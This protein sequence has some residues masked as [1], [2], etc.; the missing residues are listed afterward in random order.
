MAAP[1]FVFVRNV[2]GSN[3][4][5]AIAKFPVATTQTLVAGD[6]VVLSSGQLIKASTSCASV[7]G[8]MAQD[9][10]TQAAGTLVSIFVTKRSQVWAAAADADATTY[11]LK[12]QTQDI[13]SGQVVV[14]ADTSGGSLQILGLGAT[15]TDVYINFCVN[16]FA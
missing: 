13:S 14:V 11:V 12:S 16:D 2:D 7:S 10:T 3:N 15:T 5:P 1:H 8:V 9:S 4:P 6:A